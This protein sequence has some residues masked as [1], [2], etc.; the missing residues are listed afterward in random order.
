MDMKM[1]MNISERKGQMLGEREV[2]ASADEVSGSGSSFGFRGKL[3]CV[4]FY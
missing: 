4:V 1:N 2:S 3:G